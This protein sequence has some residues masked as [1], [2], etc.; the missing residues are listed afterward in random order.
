MSGEVREDS[1]HLN[2]DDLLW[3]G[4]SEQ[5][6]ILFKFFSA[7]GFGLDVDDVIGDGD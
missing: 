4:V 1:G 7:C 2:I 5:F 3:E 6:G